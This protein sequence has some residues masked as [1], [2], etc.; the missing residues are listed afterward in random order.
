MSNSEEPDKGRDQR[1]DSHMKQDK[2]DSPQPSVVSMK[3]CWSK[4]E[5]HDIK[6]VLHSVK[7]S[8]SKQQSL[9]SPDPS[10][11]S[12][13]SQWSKAEP[14]FQFKV[15]LHFSKSNNQNTSEDVTDQNRQIDLDDT[16]MLLEENI[17]SF[18]K[19][20]LNTFKNLLSPNCPQSMERNKKDIEEFAGEEKRSN[21]EALLK[22]TLSHL[23][24]MNQEE[25]ADL[26][27]SKTFSAICQHKLKSNLKERFQRIFE[28]IAKPGKP[29]SMDQIY[30][31]LHITEGESRKVNDQHEVRTIQAASW[32]HDKP[33][34]TIR[35]HDIFKFGQNQ[36]VRTV[37][38]QGVAGV[39]K[40][41]LT[42]KYTLDWA[43]NK[44]N[45]NI[46][47]VFPFTFRELN[48]LKE[49]TYS[50]V[51]LLHHFFTE[52]KEAGIC[53]FEEF[54][55]VFILDGLDE[56]RLRLDFQNHKI[57][58][59]VTESTS[60][61]VLLTNLIRGKLLPSGQ[62]WI[63]TRPAAASQI[64]PE[65]IDV[66][67]EV[68]G[69]TDP[70]KEEY[71]RKYFRNEETASR[72]ISHIKMSRSLHI[73]CHI[74][75]FCWVTAKV[76]DHVLKT[77]E[78]ADLPKSLTEMYI[79]FLVVQTKRNVK[80]YG[81]A[82]TDRLWNTE[83]MKMIGA[84][85]K[86][87]FEQLENGNLIFYESDLMEC[88]IDIK[89]ASVYSGLFTQIFKEER[90][91]Y[92][93]KVFCFVHLSIQEFLAALYV[94]L[95]FINTGVD[96]LREKQ[97][98]SPQMKISRV[99]FKVKNIYQRAVDKALQSPNG[100]LDLFV[101]FLLGLSLDTNQTPLCG[102][103]KKTRGKPPTREK[104][105]QYIKEKIRQNP[106][107]E[108]TINLFHCLNELHD[109]SLEYEIQQYLRSG[110]ISKNK[111]A[112]AQWCALVFILLSS[113][114]ELDVFDL[115][116]FSA[117]EEGLL[118]L[119]SVVKASKRA[120]LSGCNLSQMSC[121][122]IGSI[123][124][125][126]DSS[127]TQLDLSNNDLEDKGV[128]L[129]CA[130]LGSPQCRL[131]ILSLSSCLVTKDSC[132]SLAIALKSNPGHLRELD[133]TYN[134]PGEEG[135]KLLSALREDPHYKLDILRFH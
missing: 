3:S 96:L 62:L 103:L 55:V 54:Q 79:H 32:K 115:K 92:L 16:F 112:P 114:K 119:S 71:F 121:S 1:H 61:D 104:V 87:A 98:L 48:L 74:P 9:D 63:T 113:Q 30:T 10:G 99:D 49:K 117:S 75:V 38:T 125:S 27:Q 28:G 5:N 39:G 90:G 12:M 52:T 40:T 57:L 64:P 107:A 58:T 22:I 88:G 47:F 95:T 15:G 80:Y 127:L 2:R 65:C 85:G 124:M 109:H 101:R 134:H 20:Q 77:S 69:F 33:E 37:L 60:L 6:D 123:F 26:L 116:M 36:S 131:E 133:L 91:L 83:N 84:L 7:Q 73:M 13:K 67:T 89:T 108:R 66:I 18:V 11:V 129:L 100:H 70:Q 46:H 86:L 51:E 17:V 68:R 56:C 72:I 24:S 34:T 59:D 41:V 126:K 50:L 21:Q 135:E 128:K 110:D 97:L 14:P 111:L 25:L 35:C 122:T 45:H 93:N 76:L 132:D 19:T 105:V 82:E 8:Q 94:F 130:G 23:R 118:Q 53:T 29:T 78:K 4:A 31:E 44:T 102:L 81:R 106:C 43:E 42:Q 120:L